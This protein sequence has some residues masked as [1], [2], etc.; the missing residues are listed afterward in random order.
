MDCLVLHDISMLVCHVLLCSECI[1]GQQNVMYWDVIHC[2]KAGL[3]HVTQNGPFLG[4][5]RWFGRVPRCK[6]ALPYFPIA[7][8]SHA[9]WP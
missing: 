3:A 1:K 9:G 4:I 5:N 2:E 8:S 7:H 6:T